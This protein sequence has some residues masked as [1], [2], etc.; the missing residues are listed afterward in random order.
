MMDGMVFVEAG[1]GERTRSRVSAITSL[2][3]Q[4]LA[5]AAICTVPLLKVE[6]PPALHM[7]AHPVITLPQVMQLVVARASSS[8]MFGHSLEAPR[9]RALVVPATIPHGVSQ[10][11]QEPTPVLTHGACPSCTG[12]PN[13]QWL[14]SVLG[15]RS[16]AIVPAPHAPK[17]VRI[18]HM[19]EGLLVR[20]VKPLY[21]SIAKLAG[22]QG[23]VV[24][25]AVISRGGEIQSLRAVSGNPLLVQA[26]LQAVRQWRYRPYLLNGAAV[27]VE[28]EISVNFTPGR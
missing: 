21:P 13:A 1:R 15:P 17:V 19:D 20:Q 2:G 14:S 12:K 4:A 11:G 24:L 3:F 28:T 18:S 26:A 22:V 5:L 7:D 6:P 25:Q 16:V 10:E 9:T 27:E 23:T 8:P